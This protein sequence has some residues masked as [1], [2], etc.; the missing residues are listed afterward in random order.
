VTTK[1]W[2]QLYSE[3]SRLLQGG[4]VEPAANALIEAIDLA[5]KEPKLYEQL[6]QVTLMMGSTQ[7]AVNAAQALARVRPGPASEWLWAVADMAHGNTTEAKRRA[8]Q[9]TRSDDVAVRAQAKA[10]LAQLK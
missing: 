10:M 9:L 8:T 1:T 7:T 4:Q 2:T 5:P 6:I 3:A